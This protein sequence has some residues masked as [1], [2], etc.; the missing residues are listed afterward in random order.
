[1]LSI[2]LLGVAILA[3]SGIVTTAG[4]LVQATDAVACCA[5][6]KNDKDS[7][8]EPC[9]VPDC[10]CASCLTIDLLPHPTIAR[11]TVGVCA[12]S[13][14]QVRFPLSEFMNTIDYPPEF[15]PLLFPQAA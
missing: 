14:R 4:A 5:N 10:H 7:A 9:S 8:G 3:L 1:M 2:M 15:S 13:S 11:T 6:E 12:F